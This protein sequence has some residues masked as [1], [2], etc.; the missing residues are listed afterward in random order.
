MCQRAG[1]VEQG[2]WYW[3]PDI[4]Q[5]NAVI[6]G[7]HQAGWYVRLVGRSADRFDLLLAP[8]RTAVSRDLRDRRAL[9]TGSGAT[10]PRPARR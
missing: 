3:L 2:E 10:M 5:L 8:L 7:A 1:S 4:Q 9:S 6:H